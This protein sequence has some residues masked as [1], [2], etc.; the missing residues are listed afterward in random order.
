MEAVFN[1]IKVK[2]YFK[3]FQLFLYYPIKIH[4]FTHNPGQ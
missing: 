1:I 3:I 4:H 2:L